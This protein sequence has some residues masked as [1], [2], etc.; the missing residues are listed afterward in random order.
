MLMLIG[1]INP[2]EK[3]RLTSCDRSTFR[4][5]HVLGHFRDEQLDHILGHIVCHAFY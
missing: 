4:A 1:R 3:W 5:I 2:G